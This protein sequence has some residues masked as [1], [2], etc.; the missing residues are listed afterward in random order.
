MFIRG[1]ISTHLQGIHEF[2]FDVAFD[3][4][5]RQEAGRARARDRRSKHMRPDKSK[6]QNITDY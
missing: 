2:L 6:E 3:D 5:K 1:L 4:L